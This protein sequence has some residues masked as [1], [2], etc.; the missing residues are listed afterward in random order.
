VEEPDVNRPGNSQPGDIQAFHD[1]MSTGDAELISKTID[2]TE[3]G[4]R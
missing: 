3:G 2:Q 4:N 1:A